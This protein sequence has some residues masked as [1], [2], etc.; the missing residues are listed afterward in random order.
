MSTTP[1]TTT[2][3][4]PL[5]VQIDLTIPAKTDAA[6]P[7]RQEVQD[8][9]ALV[10]ALGAVVPGLQVVRVRADDYDPD[11]TCADCGEPLHGRGTDGLCVNCW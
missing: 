3:S 1:T 10:E 4:Q 11:D 5:R 2:T 6:A 9:I 7:V 8:V